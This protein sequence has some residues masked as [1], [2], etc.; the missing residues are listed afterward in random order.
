MSELLNADHLVTS[1][2]NRTMYFL[3]AIELHHSSVTTNRIAMDSSLLLNFSFE[4]ARIRRPSASGI[5]GIESN[6]IYYILATEISEPHELIHRLMCGE[7]FD[8]MPCMRWSVI[9]RRFNSFVPIPSN[10]DWFEQHRPS[11]SPWITSQTMGKSMKSNNRVFHSDWTREISFGTLRMKELLWA[12]GKSTVARWLLKNK[13]C[14]RSEKEDLSFWQISSSFRKT[15][16]FRD[17]I[18]ENTVYSIRRNF[19]RRLFHVS[20]T[21]RFIWESNATS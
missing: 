4:S 20:A 7:Q 19:W 12:K 1:I 3:Q 18:A 14:L 10:L 2:Q 21:Y 16:H 13:R 5:V 15:N 9:V 11:L 8:W 17:R 6:G